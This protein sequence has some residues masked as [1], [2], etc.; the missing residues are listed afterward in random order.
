[1]D[2]SNNSSLYLKEGIKKTHFP[3]NYRGISLLVMLVNYTLLNIRLSEY[4]ETNNILQLI[5]LS[6]FFQVCNGVRQG[7]SISATLFSL[8]INERC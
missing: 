8:F 5:I 1:M 4:L 7:D 2:K 3:L 6:N